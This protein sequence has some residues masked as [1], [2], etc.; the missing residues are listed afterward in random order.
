VWILSLLD[1]QQL[2]VAVPNQTTSPLKQDGIDR[3]VQYALIGLAIVRID[4]TG[5][6]HGLRS[7]FHRT[8]LI[9]P[10][11]L[12]TTAAVLH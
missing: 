8:E 7:M 9:P 11:T 6:E 4:P 3:K 5:V 12:S 1:M 10:F 2:R